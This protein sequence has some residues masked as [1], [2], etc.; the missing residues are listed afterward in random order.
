MK[1]AVVLISVVL[2]SLLMLNSCDKEDELLDD[3][4]IT[5]YDYRECLCCGGLIVNFGGS[6]DTFPDNYFLIRNKPE[7]T[8]L[9]PESDFPVFVHINWSVVKDL[10]GGDTFIDV[11]ELERQ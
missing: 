8:D 4:V 1:S 7:D 11:H 3:A 2:V 5:G 6:T 10:C 9:G